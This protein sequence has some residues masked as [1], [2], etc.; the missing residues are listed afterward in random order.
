MERYVFRFG[1]DTP[2][3]AAGYLAHGWDDEGSFGFFVDAESE[4]DAFVWGRLVANAYV[5]A[6][7]DRAGAE[8]ETPWID[9]GFAHGIDPNPDPWWFRATPPRTPIVTFGVMPDFALPEWKL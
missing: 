8:D 9:N 7:W 3:F 6:V 2:A 5:K 1:F 4:A